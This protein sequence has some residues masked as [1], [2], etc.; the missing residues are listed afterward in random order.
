MVNQRTNEKWLLDL[1]CEGD[2]Q[3]AALED[4]RKIILRGLPFALASHLPASHPE[5]Q[6]LIEEVAQDTL[7]RVL[8]RLDTFE[9]RSQFTTWVHKIAIR[10]AFSELRRRRW[11]DVSLEDRMENEDS[12]GMPEPA[13]PSASPEAII[14]RDDLLL[15]INRIVQEELTDKQRMA[16][17]A[18]ALKGMPMEE[19]AHRMDMQRNALYKLLHDARKRLKQRLEEEGLTPDSVMATFEQGGR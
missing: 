18:V 11:R 9:G 13:D 4:L 15:R 5:H 8:D 17:Q 6:S 2:I 14:E 3:A 12:P 16:L 7:L 1:R 19:V 10:M